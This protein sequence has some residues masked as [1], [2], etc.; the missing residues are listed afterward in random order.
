[1]KKVLVNAYSAKNFGDDLFLKI[2]FDRYSDVQ[3]ILRDYSIHNGVNEYKRV[4]KEYKNIK[5]KNI[6][7]SKYKIINKFKVKFN[8]NPS[9]KNMVN[10]YD[11]G[12]YIGG[13]IFM[14]I[15][16]WRNQ[17]KYRKDL[18]NQFLNS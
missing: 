4:L 18:I 5:Y 17:Y 9:V 1:M 10:K 11:A 7:T 2:L 13:S 8:I 14:Q 16:Q 15:P 12:I 3:W 6:L